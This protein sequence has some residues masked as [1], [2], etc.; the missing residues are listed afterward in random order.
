MG[1]K[2]Y[3]FNPFSW[4]KWQRSWLPCLP[5]WGCL[6]GC[7]DFLESK[8]VGGAEWTACHGICGLLHT[9]TKPGLWNLLGICSS[10]ICTCADKPGKKKTKLRIRQGLLIGSILPRSAKP[11]NVTV[12][13]RIPPETLFNIKHVTSFWSQITEHGSLPSRVYELNQPHTVWMK[14]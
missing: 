7:Q 12:I 13:L 3:I 2:N 10:V 14:N 9:V 11:L 6:V 5:P 4:K 1:G 8:G